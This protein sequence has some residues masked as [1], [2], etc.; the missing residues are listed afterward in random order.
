MAQPTSSGKSHAWVWIVLVVF[1]W[2]A[3]T[4]YQRSREADPPTSFNPS[5]ELNQPHQ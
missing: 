3:W 4:M 1:A 2:V 5:V